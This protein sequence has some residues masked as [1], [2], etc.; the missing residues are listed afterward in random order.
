V[1]AANATVPA[2]RPQG[3]SPVL[4][5]SRAG[6]RCA[7]LQRA[8]GLPNPT[9]TIDS[10]V[11]HAPS[12]PQPAANAFAPPT[13]AL[14]EHCELVGTIDERTGVNGQRYAI[15]FHLRLPTEWNGRFFFQGGG[16]SNGALGNALGALQGQQPGVALALG[17]AVVSQDAGHDNMRNNDP[18]RGGTE[19]FGLDPQARI[20]F[21]YHSYDEVARAAKAL[22]A[23]FYGRAPERSYYVGCSEG[24]REGM[25][26][27]QRFPDA[28]DGVLAC[29]PGLR[30]PRAAVAEAWDSQAFARV[31]RARNLVDADGQPA[32]NKTFTDEDLALVA[33]AV[34]AACDSLDGAADGLVQNFTACTTAIVE[35]RLAALT[36]AAEKTP[37]CL[38]RVQIA[39]LET[40][41]AGARTSTGVQVYPGWPWDAGIGGRLG[42]GY[43]QGWRSWKLG[44]YAAPRNTAIN[45]TL[46][47]L[48][49]PL[50]FF[51]PPRPVP[52][53]G[54]AAAAHSFSVSMDEALRLLENTTAMYRE[55]ALEFMRADSTDLAAF[56]RRGG[57][58][59][60]VHGVSDP[61]FSIFDTIDWWKTV[62]QVNGGRA[63]DFVRLFAV[64]GMNHCGGGPAT[65]Q[66]D[67]FGALVRWVER[68]AAPDRIVATARM[69]TPWPG[70]T[71]PLCSYPAQARYTGTGSLEDEK[72]FVCQ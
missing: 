53:T 49:L 30:L 8:A 19:T 47:A 66:F 9:T 71:R 56:K 50:V 21:G 24:G 60:I 27:A 55:S 45:L 41:F 46:G 48:A 32:I 1:V 64:P 44:A 33:G 2:A 29:S 62:D 6:E 42:A 69:P 37:A 65:D 70:R 34:L 72:N 63:A 14:P 15:R 39:A 10:A 43:N 68:G 25:M 7:E 58:L 16:G 18:E 31:A 57:K 12:P 28:F 23:R 13:P 59:I 36:C 67:A 22:I 3:A 35:P 38:D 54:G 52:A 4:P 17:Y 5:A 11:L 51:T 20:D 61:V 26:M 40:V